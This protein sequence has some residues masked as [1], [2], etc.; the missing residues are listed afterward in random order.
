MARLLQWDKTVELVEIEHYSEPLIVDPRGHIDS[1][2]Y[3]DIRVEFESARGPKGDAG[4][5]MY[6]VAP[7]DKLEVDED[8]PTRLGFRLM[9]KGKVR[10]G[11]EGIWEVASCL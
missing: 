4:D 5:P 1:V 10:R 3:D 11:K 6:I 2:E 8:D 9:H 7:Y